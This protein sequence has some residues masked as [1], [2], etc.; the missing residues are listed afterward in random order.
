VRIITDNGIDIDPRRIAG[1]PVHIVP[2]V[3]N[4]DEKVYRGGVDIQSDEFYRMLKNNP[5]K[6]PTTSQ[7]SPGDFQTVYTEQAKFDS[8][9]ISIHMSAELSGTYNSA[10]LASEMV[11]DQGINVTVIDSKLVSGA[12]AWLVEAAAKAAQAGASRTEIITLVSKLAQNIRLIFSPDTLK[13]L[14]HGGRVS[15]LKGFAASLL[16][17]KPMIQ[18]KYETGKLDQL[19]TVRTMKKALAQQVEQIHQEIGDH[20]ARIQIIHADNPQGATE[21]HGLLSQR[22]DC[23]FMPTTNVTPVV[24]AHTGPGVVGIV[25]AKE[26]FFEGL[27]T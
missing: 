8:E 4:F 21:V 15:H 22:L 3:I 24:G 16:N 26:S 23:H 2:L 9:I 7:P 12:E 1:L 18:L 5:N 11:K 14:V 17:I 27:P 20:R 25:Y 13:Y 10:R 6:F 19:G